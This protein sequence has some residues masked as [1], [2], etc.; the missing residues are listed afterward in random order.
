MSGKDLSNEPDK[1]AYGQYSSSELNEMIN[2][3]IQNEDYEK[4]S[5]IRD[6]L[7]KRKK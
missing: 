6:E 3:A 1:P 2:E 7:K 4:A 5:I